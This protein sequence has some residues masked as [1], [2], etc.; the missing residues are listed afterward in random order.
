V[1]DEKD[2][3]QLALTLTGAKL[4]LYSHRK[5]GHYVVFA[6]SLDEETLKPLV[7]YYSIDEKTRWTRTQENF[8]ELVDG[9]SR[10]TYLREAKTEEFYKAVGLA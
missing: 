1:S 10:F 8:E 2:K 4:G 9:F 3:A 6:V 7:H 5:G